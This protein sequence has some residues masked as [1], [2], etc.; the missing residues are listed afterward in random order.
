MIRVYIADDHSIVRE[1]MR[2]LI[3]AAPDMEVVGEAP[4]GDHALR[5]IPSLRPDVFLM[6]MS[7]PGCS[8]LRLIETLGRRAPDTRI[9]VLSMHQEDLYA[10]R[11]VRAGAQGFITKTRPPDELLDA[12]REVAAGQ[13]YVTRELAQKLAREALTGHPQAQPHASLTRREY[14]I[15]IELAQGRTVGVIADRLNVSSKTVSTHK[16]R[17]MDKLQARSLSDLVRY[18]MNHNLI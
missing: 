2:A 14:E 15:F 11:T 6:D 7:M 10:T 13:L 8:G 18:A 16:A 12:L 1:G 3:A 4:D 17:L 5:E 9:L